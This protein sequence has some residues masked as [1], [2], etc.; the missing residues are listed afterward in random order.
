M[1]NQ[2]KDETP[3]PVPL[4]LRAVSPQTS[5]PTTGSLHRIPRPHSQDHSVDDAVQ[6]GGVKDGTCFKPW[7]VTEVE[8]QIF[9]PHYFHGTILLIYSNLKQSE[10]LPTNNT[11]FMFL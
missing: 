6:V 5:D 10:S 8:D 2:Q 9:H 1:G 4:G 7:R 3:G 11:Q